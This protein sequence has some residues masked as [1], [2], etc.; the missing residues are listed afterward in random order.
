MNSLIDSQIGIW[1]LA[2]TFFGIEGV[3]AE[4]VK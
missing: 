3:R 4:P 1:V 2:A